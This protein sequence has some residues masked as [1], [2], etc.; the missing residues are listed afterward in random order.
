MKTFDPA[1]VLDDYPGRTDRELAGLLDVSV[2][3]IRSWRTGRR[4]LKATQADTLAIRVGLHPAILWP[5][6]WLTA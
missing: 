4:Q 5:D 3:T 6:Q 2:P 1:P